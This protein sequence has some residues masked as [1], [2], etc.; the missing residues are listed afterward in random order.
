MS[1]VLGKG[2]SEQ[3]ICVL[4]TNAPPSLKVAE[5]RCDGSNGPNPVFHLQS[6][7]RRPEAENLR[8]IAGPPLRNLLLPARSCAHRSAPGQRYLRPRS[9]PA[10]EERPPPRR[11]AGALVICLRRQQPG[12]GQPAGT[13]AAAAGRSRS[14]PRSQPGCAEEKFAPRPRPPSPPRRR[15]RRAA[16]AG[17]GELS[18]A[19][20]PG[21]GRPRRT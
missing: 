5:E 1:A 3:L 6:P 12:S 2:D 18:S 11:E 17:H 21:R 19:R 9:L 16:A 15:P 7:H 4:V 10:P 8:Q 14:L 13:G 20:Q